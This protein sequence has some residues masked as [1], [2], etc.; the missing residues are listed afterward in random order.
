MVT[1]AAPA[2]GAVIAP[3]PWRRTA[4]WPWGGKC[5]WCRLLVVMGSF[6]RARMTQSCWVLEACVSTGLQLLATTWGWVLLGESPSSSGVSWARGPHAGCGSASCPQASGSVLCHHCNSLGFTHCL[7]PLGQGV[8][9]SLRHLGGLQPGV[10]YLLE[11]FSC[12]FF[13]FITFT[14]TLLAMSDHNNIISITVVPTAMTVLA[15]CAE[16][17]RPCKNHRPLQAAWLTGEIQTG[18]ATTS[19]SRH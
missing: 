13:P 19:F 12:L 11:P 4:S 8:L 1:G 17:S 15:N 10:V 16:L 9:G 14:R 6:A 7:L 5:G 18:Q 2:A 3:W